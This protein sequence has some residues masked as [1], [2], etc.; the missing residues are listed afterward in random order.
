ML[1]IAQEL[2]ETAGVGGQ[3]DILPVKSLS[4]EGGP[5]TEV[6]ALMCRALQQALF[7]AE[8]YVTE[9]GSV[10]TLRSELSD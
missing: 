7:A 8:D 4:D 5:T 9:Y 1:L 2:E 3:K 10:A 6:S